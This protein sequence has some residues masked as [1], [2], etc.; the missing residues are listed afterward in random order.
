ML[1][2]ID[3]REHIKVVGDVAKQKWRETIQ[4]I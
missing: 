4:E 3:V 2:I 1:S